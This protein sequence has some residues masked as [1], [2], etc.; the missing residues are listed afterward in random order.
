[1]PF[2]TFTWL[3]NGQLVRRWDPAKTP[4]PELEQFD[5]KLFL[6]RR[7]FGYQEPDN[8]RKPDR[9]R[10][11]YVVPGSESPDD[12]GDPNPDQVVPPYPKVRGSTDLASVPPLFWWLVASYGNHTRAALLHD[13]LYIETG[14]PP[15]D[16]K[17]ADSLFLTALRE[18]TDKKGGAFRHWLMW[19]AVS[20]F[21][22]LGKLRGALLATH[23]VAVW[24]LVIV[25]L[26]SEWGSEI[27]D[28]PWLWKVIALVCAPPLFM[29]LLG[30][31]WRA[32]VDVT[33]GWLLPSAVLASLIGVPLAVLWESPFW[34]SAPAT[35]LAIAGVLFLLGFA[36]GLAVVKDLRYWL[37][38]TTLIG[39]PIAVVPLVLIVPSVILVAFIDLGAELSASVQ[40][41]VTGQKR[42]FQ[43]P[44]IG[45]AFTRRL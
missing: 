9:L 33:G 6:L 5:T 21:G 8:P 22:N 7:S 15:V 43:R 27:W 40:T 12:Q 14:T 41:D 11:M 38:P 34:E 32:R 1:M 37:W 4:N 39:L 17:T 28:L 42:T 18:P 44:R 45:E 36:W 20:A 35:L 30:L 3:E 24:V 25:A 2:G 16:R 19:A 13:S 23:A 10:P 26:A 31:V 29:L